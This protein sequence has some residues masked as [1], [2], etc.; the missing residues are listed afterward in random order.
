M[1][2]PSRMAMRELVPGDSGG[3]TEF[4]D[5]KIF[6][7]FGGDKADKKFVSICT[8]WLKLGRKFGS[9]S[10]HEV[11]KFARSSG[12]SSALGLTFCELKKEQIRFRV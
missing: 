10:Q 3:R 5:V 12:A 7:G 8:I 4:S 11:I 1:G 6:T 2:A 9:S